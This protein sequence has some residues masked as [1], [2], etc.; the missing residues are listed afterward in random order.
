MIILRC[1]RCD[2]SYEPGQMGDCPACDGILQPGYRDAAVD[3]LVS[4]TPGRG[5]D[6]YRATLPADSPLP[7]LGE[8]DTPLIPSRAIGPELGLDYLYFKNEGVNPSGAFKD[9][10][11]TLVAALARDAGGKRGH[12]GLV[13][14]RQLGHLRLL[15]GGRP[16]MFR[17][18]GAWQSA[19]QA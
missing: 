14:Q 10:A 8:G 5:I 13:G 15:C 1:I 6:R 17:P 9:R 12:N 7:Y 2:A 3:T 19:G 11:G 18:H 16:G 4:I